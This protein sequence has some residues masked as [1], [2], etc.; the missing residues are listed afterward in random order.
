M[1]TALTAKMVLDRISV[2]RKWKHLK[3]MYDE[4]GRLVEGDHDPLGEFLVKCIGG[5]FE[6]FEDFAYDGAKVLGALAGILEQAWSDLE[7]ASV[8]AGEMCDEWEG[9]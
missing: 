8:I 3:G 5:C 4:R 6:E 1:T 2:D 9:A 7:V